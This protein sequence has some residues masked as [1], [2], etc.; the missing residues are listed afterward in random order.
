LVGSLTISELELQPIATARRNLLELAREG[1]FRE[2]LA[3]VLST[4]IIDL[5]PLTERRNDIPLVAQAFVEE[6]NAEGNQQRGGFTPEALDLLAAYSWPGNLDE[7]ASV[8][9]EA[10]RRAERPLI[11]A[12]DVPHKIHLATGTAAGGRPEE[13][14]IVLGDFL[15]QIESQLI[16]RAL[17]RA[18]GNKALAARM[19]GINRARLLRRLTQLRL[20]GSSQ[21][22]A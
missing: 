8:V 5:P 18:K 13:D 1:G 21:S 7:L 17:K 3:H 10:H 16:K 9:R 11:G 19:L 12:A 15:E 22:D 4:L 20:A 2:D 6:I 14:S